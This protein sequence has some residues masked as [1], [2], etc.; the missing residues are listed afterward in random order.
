MNYLSYNV[1][2]E[3][4]TY[5]ENEDIR[6]KIELPNSTIVVIEESINFNDILYWEN[7][8][9]SLANIEIVFSK[10]EETIGCLITIFA[11]GLH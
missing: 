9:N 3:L 1:T 5:L 4:M 6:H 8:A 11:T 10:D 7:C 2:L